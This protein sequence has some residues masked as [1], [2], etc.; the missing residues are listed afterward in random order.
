MESFEK[1]YVDHYPLVYD[2]LLSLCRDPHTA[3]ELTQETFFKVFRKLDSYRG[4]CKFS[5]WACSI[6]K[7]TYVSYLR[8][9]KRLTELKED[10]P[11][12]SPPI[13]EAL[14]D[15][16]LS[17]KIHEKLHLLN[18]PYKEVFWMRVFG[19]LPFAEIARLHNKTESWARV[20]FHRA[21]MMIKEE[22][23]E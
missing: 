12:G 1:L 6:A 23:E 15:R 8:K 13:E 3:E 14:A 22:L 20:T 2:Y 19:E 7:N 5:T 4:D 21:K 9:K 17:H 11:D 10:M 18:D 16:E